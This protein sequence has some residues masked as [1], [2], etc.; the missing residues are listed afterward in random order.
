VRAVSDVDRRQ[1]RADQERRVVRQRR[2]AELP[3][4]KPMNWIAVLAPI[5]ADL[6]KLLLERR[7]P[8]AAGAAAGPPAALMSDAEADAMA[9]RL[10][11]VV[12][13]APKA[14][15]ATGVPQPVGSDAGI[16][17]H[18]QE[19]IDALRARD[20]FKVGDWLRDFVNHL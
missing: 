8:R 9:A 5:I 1:L 20:W 14:Q 16:I 3:W 10:E 17:A 7:R 13:Q 18:V 12:A 15:G 4:E 19:L 2:L 11:Q 6:V